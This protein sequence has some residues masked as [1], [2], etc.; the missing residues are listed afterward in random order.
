[1]LGNR[2]GWLLLALIGVGPVAAAGDANR[3]AYLDDFCN[4]YYVGLDTAKLVTPQWIGEPGVEAVIVLS[5]DD[6]IDPP[7]Y[8]QF[9]RPIL[10]RLKKID[11]RAPV[12][13]MTKHVD[14]NHPQLP[15]WFSEGVTVEAHTY[16]HP[17]PCLQG[18]D[19]A[20]AKATYDRCI[21]LLSR[22]PGNPPVAFRMPCCD[23]MNSVGPR[24][25]A[26]LFN[27]T[28]PEGRFLR[29][30]SSVFML[31]T[32][33]DPVL[34]REVVFE[35]DGRQRFAKYVPRDRNFVN[36]VEDYPYPYVVDRLCWEIPT[37][38]PDDWQGHNL[39]G[40][41][42][43]TTVRDMK[44]AI[45][46]AV[47]KQGI[48]TLTHH[49]GGWIRNDQV[50]EL[51]EHAV[52]G[53]EGKVKFLNLRDVYARLTKNML[54]GHPL[55][56]DDGGAGG[57]CILDVNHDGYMDAVVA[58][59]K[60]R[61]TR[62]W[63]A[64]TRQWTT[65]DFPVEIARTREHRGQRDAGVR[66]GVLQ[67]NGF[68]SI[69]VRNERVAGVWHFDG[70]RWAQDPHGLDGLDLNG[71][72]FTSFEGRDRG[73]RLRDLDGDGICEL[74]VS[75]PRQNGV[76]RRR[77]GRGGWDRLP[78]SLPPG[79]KIVD[80]EGR[81]AGMRLVDIDED[82][83][84][85]VV[86][87]NAERYSLHVFISMSDGWSREILSGNRGDAGEIPMIVRADGTNN[88]AWFH[89]RHLYVQNEE[90]GAKLPNHIDSRSYTA[91]LDGDVEPPARSP[92]GSLRA[93]H[94][95]PGFTVE[96]MAAEPLV[97]DPIDVAWGP[98]GKAWIVEMADY[99]LGID[100]RGK[101]GGRICFLE[102]GDGDGRYDKS[103]LFLE[104]V[105]FPLGI[106]PWRQGAIVAAAPEVFYAE[107]TDGDGK[108]DLHRTLYSGFREGNQQHRVN[109]P[110]WGLD[111][112][113]H[114]ANG[115]SG[116]TIRSA[117]TGEVCDISGR[118]LRVR[119]D[120]GLLDPETGQAQ[121]GRNRDDWGNWFGCNNNNPGWYYALAD[122]YIRRN[123]HVAAPPGRVDLTGDRDAWPAGRV[124]TH[125]YAPQPTPPE[126]KPGRWTSV[127]GV[128]IYR[129]DLFGPDYA[130]NLFVE[131]S[132][133]N[134]VHR[135][136]LRREGV[137]I[138]GQR[139]PDEERSEFL[140][141]SDPYFRPAT[142][143]T[144]PDGALWVVDMYRFVIEHPEWIDA[145]LARK[146]DLRRHHDRGRIYRIYPVDKKPRPIPRL[147]TLDTAGL[148]AA[149]D[150]SN[151]WQRDMAHQMLLWRA[152]AAAVGPL[153]TM[154][155]GN[156][157]PLARLH[158][159]CVL[160]GLGALKPEVAIRALA[161]EHPG[162]RRHAVRVSELLVGSS[163]ALG[164][165]L[166]ERVD[167]P[168]AQ[169]RMQLAYSL[170]EWDDPRAGQALARLALG[171][172]GD[173]YLAAAVMSSAPP[174]VEAMLSALRADSG[175]DAARADL[176][177]KLEKLARDVRAQPELTARHAARP[178]RA[179]R[180]PSE[181]DRER[182]EK[183]LGRAATL[184]Q[185]QKVLAQHQPV[186]GT[187]G[188]S[189]RGREMFVEATCSNC[190]RLEGLGEE[191]GPDLRTLTDRS[192][193]NLLVSVIDPNRAV[194]E[195][196][197]EYI[198]VTSDGLTY[199]GMLLEETSNSITLV[200]TEGERQVI[201]RKDLDE[202]V[203]TGRSHMPEGLE[204]K[205]TFRQMADLFAFVAQ[206]A[207][208]R[209]EVPGN[210]PEL[211]TAEPD[212]SLRLAAAKCEIYSLGIKMSGTEFLVW[213][214][215]GPGDHVVWS[216][217]VPKSGAYEV[218]IE[219]AQ[220]D[221][222]ADNPIA[223]EVEGTSTRLATK[224]P[225]T[226]GWGNV[227]KEK[228]GLLPLEAGRRRIRF[229][230]NG[231]NKTEVSDL[232]GLHLIPAAQGN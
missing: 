207:P 220:I 124:I 208:V 85:D 108:A 161:D 9:L 204:A 70:R 81:D 138:R 84:P 65:T 39:F 98:D 155:V 56:A 16:D 4:P 134:V 13:I 42:N 223:I 141:S 203:Y 144:G 114:L 136:I 166:L 20:K 18:N 159:I 64:Q 15:V 149:L 180:R 22:I 77:T 94:P 147:D 43:P 153:E 154:A 17:C 105:N 173:V 181:P 230:P 97:R 112:W 103:T 25:F 132:V 225:S 172:A 133:Y 88:G 27:K 232:R 49:P 158:A 89:Y 210:R 160:D 202:L 74:V 2:L 226:G 117:R 100:G 50:I 23:S 26:E 228:F 184:E 157:R 69:L 96:L 193:Q 142:M 14:L 44:A 87:S 38:V 61:E 31:F 37:A 231:P 130:G 80:Q 206:C 137:L 127:A 190:H 175:E 48:F 106:M 72:L 78:F 169:V 148:V 54:G 164:E 179:L 62:I 198:A 216:V 191:I 47:I 121:Y 66:F 71:A 178:G 197:V 219:W 3:L 58:N 51:V 8:E 90:T 126:G 217:D 34:P 107:D 1:M 156:R 68:A 200:D 7:R 28:T 167:D 163:P 212:G 183:L 150:S 118:D 41:H 168:D 131:D 201:L 215:K 171:D 222:Y 214:Y 146:L 116:G 30:D 125:C 129:D 162:V 12:S 57:V 182:V 59:E 152:D 139:G 35:E 46:A 6:M 29:A 101:P 109:H 128:M 93:M 123:P 205:M 55:R 174:H 32:P 194:L 33:D 79:T 165:A 119:P 36:Y 92:E 170:G 213:F 63:S 67:D 24:F 19:F 40:P 73:V 192:P 211:V 115:D 86:F 177:A 227:R 195:R 45:D 5:I 76:F 10:Q 21:D 224:L 53:R 113:I 209:Q 122:H 52:A 143:R 151:G 135:M 83:R 186:L 221:E 75:N 104:P 188:E 176:V 91:L 110:R 102:D 82:V 196:F 229:R 218:W 189:D 99:P 199:P 187:F 140:A 11:G 120:E 145:G 95:R 111:N 60:A 185:V